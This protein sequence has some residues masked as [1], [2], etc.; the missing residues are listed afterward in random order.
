M[1]YRATELDSN[2][3]FG[4][5]LKC[6]SNQIYAKSAIFQIRSISQHF[7]DKPLMLP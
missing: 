3:I 1:S 6:G 4:E 7:Q 2:L 5:F